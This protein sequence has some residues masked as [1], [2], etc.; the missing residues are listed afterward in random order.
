MRIFDTVMRLEDQLQIAYIENAELK[1]KNIRL[2]DAVFE[3]QKR[4]DQLSSNRNES[5]DVGYKELMERQQEAYERQIA[6]LNKTI[7]DLKKSHAKEVKELRAV[8]D[9]NTK[10]LAALLERMSVN[11]KV[12]NR[13]RFGAASEKL[14]SRTKN[15]KQEDR[16]KE[17]DD[18]DGTS[19]SGDS[20]SGGGSSTGKENT[21]DR[22]DCSAAIKKM[23]ADF[24]RTHPGASVTTERIDYS[25]AFAYTDNPNYHSLDSYF[26]LP[27]GA[28]FVT[29]KGKIETHYTRLLVCF[30]ERYEEHIF[31]TA[32]VRYPDQDDMSTVESLDIDKPIKSCC[33]STDS[34]VFIFM[35]KFYYNT[36]FEQ[37]VRKMRM[38]GVK[39]NKS[40]MIDNIHRAIDEMMVRMKSC[41]EKAI[42]S[43]RYLMI[44]ETPGLVG[45]D[46]DG[47]RSYLK[48]YFWTVTDYLKKLTWIFYEN[49]SRGAKVI[50][51]FLMNHVG[52]YTTDGYVVYKTFDTGTDTEGSSDRKRSACLVHIRRPFV[53]AMDEDYEKA[54]SFINPITEIF[55]REYEFKQAGL[56]GK[57]RLIARLGESGIR[58]LLNQIKEMIDRYDAVGYETCGEKLKKAIKYAKAE[59]DA[60]MRVLESG[61]IEVSNNISEQSVRKLKMN[62]RNAGNIGSEKSAQHNGFMFSIMESCRLNDLQ[63]EKYLA[64][65][66]RS[67]KNRG[68]D[69]DLRDLLPCNCT[70]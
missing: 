16:D 53:V 5:L 52:F 65:L 9:A 14:S 18:F 58:D 4:I 11:T 49:G 17:K 35:E 40:T 23:Q 50:K 1:D 32:I 19:C 48:K 12:N 61:D 36:P 21:G 55:A 69:E 26:S 22:M 70:L 45:C 39:M 59:W 24:L 67:L 57:D 34:L 7:K 62:L 38:R 3:L 28:Y 63:P 8:I 41:W 37:I 31:E 42:K 66:L 6:A 51:P 46:K 27:E 54:M 43:A 20:V 33:F 56:K 60:M 29:R 15:K 68:K 30:P 13:Q 2:E 47:E 64:H 44:D 25:K 10:Q